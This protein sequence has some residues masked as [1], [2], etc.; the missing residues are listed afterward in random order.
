MK[1]KQIFTTVL[2]FIFFLS[3]SQEWKPE[4]GA[5]NQ[6]VGGGELL[7]SI[8]IGILVQ[9]QTRYPEQY[10]GPT[11]NSLYNDGAYGIFLDLY[12]KKLIIG[13]QITDEYFFISGGNDSVIKWK[14][15]GFN[16][17]FSSLT[18]TLW[19]SLG[20][21]IFSDVYLKVNIGGRR[22]PSE[23]II[24]NNI[25]SNEVASGFDFNDVSSIYNNDDNL[26]NAF[27]EIDFSFG[28]NYSV[29]ISDKLSLV[30]ELGYSF[31]YGGVI[32]G[33]S[34]KRSIK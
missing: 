18:R 31:N 22:G 34:L 19:F 20:Y 30:P 23:G 24:H 5:W 27:S 21:N 2:C 13:L 6:R 29:A 28:F 16:D 25:P 12:V 15:R 17:S 32:T 14:P 10:S 11:V 33:I 1:I 9:G 4:K 3:H 8:G 7:K 26:I